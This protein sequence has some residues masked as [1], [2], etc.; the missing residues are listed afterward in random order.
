MSTAK[1]QLQK[2]VIEIQQK[3]PVPTIDFTQHVMDDGTVVSTQE[4]VVK[5]VCIGSFNFTQF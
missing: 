5:D 2:A 4:R 3:R 1:S